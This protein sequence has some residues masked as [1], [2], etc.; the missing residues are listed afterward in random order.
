MGEKGGG[1]GGI[2]WEK[3]QNKGNI[4]AMC[5][6]MGERVGGELERVHPL[7]ALQKRQL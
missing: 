3:I 5:W 2:K 7:S 4:N 6:E 1:G